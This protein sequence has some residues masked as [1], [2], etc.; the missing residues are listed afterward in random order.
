MK[1]YIRGSAEDNLIFDE[2][3]D[4]TVASQ[5]ALNNK[6]EWDA[7]EGYQKLIPFL[8][9]KNDDEAVAQIEEIISDELNHAEVLRELMKKYDGGIPTNQE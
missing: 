8:K 3:D 5:I 4:A 9:A 6:S 7:I 2:N 1:R